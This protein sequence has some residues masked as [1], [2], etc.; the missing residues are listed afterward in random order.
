MKNLFITFEGIDGSGKDTQLHILSNLIRNEKIK[1]LGNK[2]SNI[3]ITREPTNIT[4]SG[5]K[6]SNLLLT[7]NI[8]KEDA[9][10]YYIKDRI[11][12][13]KIIKKQLKYSI[14]LCS[15]YDYS[16]FLYQ[17]SQ[18][19]NFEKLFNL[20]Y[21]KFKKCIIPDITIIFKINLK[22]HLKRCQKRK[23]KK[24]FFEEKNFQKKLISNQNKILKKLKKQQFKRKFIIINGNKKIEEVSKEIINKLNSELQHK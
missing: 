1:S 20:H 8:K 21:K 13:T 4:K 3:W 24:E 2:Y 6:I 23:H 14:V 16:T 17:T 12:H 19:E 9:T 5:I 7:K 18:G 10:K 11:Q 22:T 15:R